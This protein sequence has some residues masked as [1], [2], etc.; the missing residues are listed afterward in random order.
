MSVWRQKAIEIAPEL[1]REF[2]DPN[3][4][5]YTVFTELLFLLKQ[6]H[7]RGDVERLRKIYNYAEWCFRQ[8]E[9]KLWKAAWVSFYEH[10]G[11]T[12]ITFS[13]F[14]NWVKRE[15]YFEIRE[16]LNQRL[17]DEKM[18]KLDSYYGWTK[19]K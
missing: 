4:T 12:D 7:D 18:K 2:Q 11:D 16:L 6:A 15:I 19:W 8:K 9:Q 17:E 14:T 3:L 1:K 13:A 5:P 10:L